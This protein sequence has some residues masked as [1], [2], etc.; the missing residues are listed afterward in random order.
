MTLQ[1]SA[2]QMKAYR[3][4]AR[5]R[6]Q[7]EQAQLARR[8]ER[9]W[10]LAR[11]AAEMLRRDFAAARVVVFGSLAQEERFTEW[12]DVDLAAW[13]LDSTNWLKAIGAV[14]RLSDEIE[15]NLVDAANCSPQLLAAIEQEGMLL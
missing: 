7:A 13:G 10:E 15:L 11:Q 3:R 5:Q 6:W 2:E 1:I 12:S 4:T 14:R 8:R 9:A